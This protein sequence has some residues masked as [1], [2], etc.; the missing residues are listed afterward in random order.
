MP[1]KV[2]PNSFFTLHRRALFAAPVI[3]GFVLLFTLYFSLSLLPSLAWGA[4]VNLPVSVFSTYPSDALQQSCQT[5]RQI[6]VETKTVTSF[7]PQHE[8]IDGYVNES[9]LFANNELCIEDAISPDAFIEQIIKSGV[10]TNLR[11]FGEGNDYELLI[12]N[13]GPAPRTTHDNLMPKDAK[14]YAEFTIQWRGIEIDSASFSASLNNDTNKIKSKRQGSQ[15]GIA[16]AQQQ[17]PQTLVS[18]W[19]DY[20]ER[21]GLFTS[22]Y[23]F[24]ALEASNYESALQVPSAV[25][26]FTKLATQLYAD[27]FSGA[28][29][30]YTHPAYEDAL[31]DVTVYPFLEQLTLD[32]N[33]L[34]PKQLEEDL[35]R[36]KS[37]AQ[38]Q[39]LTLSQVKPAARYKVNN[40]IFGWRLGLSATSESS[41]SIYATTYVFRRQDKI[42]KVSTTFPPD[43]SDNIVDKLIV[44][45][46][47]PE[48]S[49]MMKN[50][51][52]L[53]LQRP[54]Q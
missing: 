3:Q 53:L 39:K 17:A 28:I 19:L 26:E 21:T 37:N 13:V 9:A 54:Q 38:I 1:V 2:N 32:E 22:Q 35:K 5:Q 6:D 43:Y 8:S 25:G 18:K 31:I 50:V 24:T 45:I 44:K 48:E 12:A 4:E 41:P 34:L 51:R 7:K 14:Q 42:I 10:F 47:V 49:K 20:A 36:A 27:P 33:E 52:A 15:E 30:R 29:T 11:P 23:L 16:N 46:E 40:Q